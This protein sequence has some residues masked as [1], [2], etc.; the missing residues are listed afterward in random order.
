MAGKFLVSFLIEVADTN[1]W[2]T[3]QPWKTTKE[4]PL[5]SQN[6]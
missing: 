1:F 2:Q 6:D 5:K 4:E 3:A